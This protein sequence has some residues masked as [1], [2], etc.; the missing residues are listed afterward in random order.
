MWV[1]MFEHYRRTDELI[2]LKFS[3]HLPIC[4]EEVI[5]PFYVE[6]SNGQGATPTY[7]T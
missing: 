1:I 6:N 7:T 3:L 2:F 5:A 4:L